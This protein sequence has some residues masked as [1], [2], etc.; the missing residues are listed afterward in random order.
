MKQTTAVIL[1]ALLASGCSKPLGKSD[2]EK[3]A[4]LEKLCKEQAIETINENSADG[5][6]L[7][8]DDGLAFALSEWTVSNNTFQ[9]LKQPEGTAKLPVLDLEYSPAYLLRN[10]LDGYDPVRE[11]IYTRGSIGTNPEIPQECRKTHMVSIKN[12]AEAQAAFLGSCDVSKIVQSVEGIRY[13]IGHAYG[14]VDNNEIRRFVFYVKDRGNGRILAEQR[15][16]QLL[17]GGLSSEKRVKHG[18]G[19]SQGTRTCKLTPPD[20]VVKRVFR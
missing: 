7:L 3:I 5:A 11:V 12:K 15:S 1:L 18:W 9:N 14:K 2:E 6:I 19:S 20:Q 10:L 4:T 17:M 13:Y 8:S 16:F